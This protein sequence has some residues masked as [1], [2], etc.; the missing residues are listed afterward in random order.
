MRHQDVVETP[1]V[2]VFSSSS[3][4]ISG[5][6]K[7]HFPKERDVDIPSKV[8]RFYFLLLKL[9]TFSPKS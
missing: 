9:I 4:F 2:E 6:L 3:L 5:Q 7:H 8:K 1:L